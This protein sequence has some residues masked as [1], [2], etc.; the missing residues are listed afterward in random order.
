MPQQ[1]Q[2]SWVQLRVGLLVIVSLTVLAL[3]I[4]FIS[5]QVSPFSR[6]YTL[7][8]YFATA[9]GVREGTEVRLAGIPVGNVHRIHI[10]SFTDPAKSVEI[11]L[12]IS[13]RY[14]NEIREDSIASQETAG[15]LGESY[16]DISRGGAGQKILTNDGELMSQQ[17]ADIKAIVQN[18][19]DVI[20]NLRVLSTKLNDIT[21]QIAEG[22]GTLGPLIYDQKLYNRID[23]AVAHIQTMINNV[24][25]GQGTL[26]KLLTD[27][28]FYQR[29]NSTLDSLNQFIADA[30]SGKG[31]LGKFVSDPSVYDN[32]NKLTVRG[33]ALMDKIESSQG[34]L[35]KLVNDPQL[36]DR[37]NSTVT[38]LDSITT[39]MDAGEGTLGKLS[40][41]ASLFN[42]LN[43]SAKSL[44]EFLDEFR[45]D[46]KK[47]LTLR[48]HIF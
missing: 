19:N 31:S 16:I 29:M 32:V 24:Q 22:K 44:K 37:V 23:Q 42:T 5:G 26:G 47:Y 1:K 15:L 11:D 8:T 14:Q 25:S 6:R 39:R 21:G 45:K 43:A 30:R 2:I 35:G 18:T 34:T 9:G 46:P 7:R 3:A 40:T 4:F 13:R 27:E 41:D 33:N 17:T 48:L 20:S 10:S 12:R 28:S 36:Y 38:H